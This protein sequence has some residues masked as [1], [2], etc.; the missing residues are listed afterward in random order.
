M[1][2]LTFGEILWYIIE[3]KECL[4]GAPFN[5]AGHAAKGGS[6]CAI[7]SCLGKDTRG[8][9]VRKEAQKLGIDCRY[10]FEQSDYPSVDHS[11]VVFIEIKRAAKGN[12][13]SNRNNGND[14][15]SDREHGV[16]IPHVR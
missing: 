2:L 10:V 5:L 15:V 11:H 6:E 8:M 1:K 13:F 14:F 3:A 4:G 7:V 9:R 16:E 12:V